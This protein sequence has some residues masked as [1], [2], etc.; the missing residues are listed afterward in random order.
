MGIDPVLDVNC[1]NAVINDLGAESFTEI[2]NL[3][4]T[5][6]DKRFS[7]LLRLIADADNLQV[8]KESHRL[9]SSSLSFG[10]VR[11]GN[12]LRLIEKTAISG[13]NSPQQLITE[14]QDLYHTS[15]KTLSECVTP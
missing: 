12:K 14:L 11:L 3:F 2:L 8:S 1:L 10:L 7:N 13:S 6:T 4:Y 15:I 5:E 9:A